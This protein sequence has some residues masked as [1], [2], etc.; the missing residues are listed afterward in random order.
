MNKTID[1]NKKAKKH[2]GL[3]LNITVS[4]EQI[5]EEERNRRLVEFFAL[6]YEW[7]LEEQSKLQPP[8]QS[9]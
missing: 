4:K 1:K 7:R 6:L 9:P 5:S 2:K 8:R 3:T